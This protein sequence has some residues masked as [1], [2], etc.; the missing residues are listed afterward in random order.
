MSLADI[1]RPLNK[2]GYKS[3]RIMA[4]EMVKE[5]TCFDRVFCS[6]AVRA[7]LTIEQIS[8]NLPG[9]K[10]RWELD[11][12]LYT[13]SWQDLLQW[14]QNLDESLHEVTIIGHNPTM[15][16]FIN[17]I[18]GT[19]LA[20]LPTCGYVQLVYGTGEWKDLSRGAARMVSFL[21]PKMFG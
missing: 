13:F 8:M 2:R 4:P 20:N 16:D 15:T 11:H 19:D 18:G 14:F 6:T 1:D 12:E 7:Q 3:C 21:K 10:I 17:E 5:R 9:Q